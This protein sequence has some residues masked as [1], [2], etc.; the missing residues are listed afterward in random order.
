MKRTVGVSNF[1][2]RGFLQHEPSAI[3]KIL[4]DASADPNISPDLLKAALMRIDMFDKSKQM[5]ALV[6]IIFGHIK[7]LDAFAY[8][9]IPALIH[10]RERDPFENVR[11]LLL[12]A[13]TYPWN[14]A[15]YSMKTGSLFYP[16]GIGAPGSTLVSVR[17]FQTDVVTNIGLY[18]ILDQMT[19]RYANPYSHNATITAS[20]DYVTV[21]HGAEVFE[22][23]RPALVFHLILKLVDMS[24]GRLQ[25]A[26]LLV[27]ISCIPK[28]L[29][30]YSNIME[31]LN[32][33]ADSIMKNHSMKGT[34][35]TEMLIAEALKKT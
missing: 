34:D 25:A 6:P 30:F 10:M 1:S 28:D 33:V 15:F 21:N 22:P 13:C 14:P 17:V 19:Q 26:I 18:M 27:C 4:I 3:G 5:E 7:A 24:P 11:S 8:S 2:L 16:F 20:M 29:W 12:C 23:F 9:S 31:A 32:E 35:L